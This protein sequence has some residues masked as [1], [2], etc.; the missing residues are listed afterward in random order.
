MLA[1]PEQPERLS[2]HHHLAIS[3][4]DRRHDA[5]G[6]HIRFLTRTGPRWLLRG[7]VNAPHPIAAEAVLLAQEILTGTK[8]RAPRHHRPGTVVEFD[9]TPSWITDLE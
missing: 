7:A 3:W 6:T 2:V 8:V 1:L 9:P 4:R 5:R